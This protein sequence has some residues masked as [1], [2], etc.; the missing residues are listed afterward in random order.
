M[1]VDV[2]PR[3]RPPRHEV[4]QRLDVQI[5]ELRQRMGGLPNPLEAADIWRGIWFE[6]AHHSTAIEGN[7]LVLKQV[8]QLLAEGRAVGNKELSE[9]LEVKGYGDA[10]EWVYGQAI[11]PEYESDEPLTLTEIRKIHHLAMQ[12]VWDIAPH[13]RATAQEGPGEFRRHDIH[14]FPGGMRPPSWVLVAGEMRSWLSATRTLRA[15]TVEFPEQAAEL[16]CRFEQIHP[17]LDG[18]G[19]TGRLVL[20]LLL[21]RLGYPPVIVYKLQRARYLKALRRADAGDFGELGELI[22]RAI[23]D[24]LYKFVVPAIAGPA[25]LVPLAALA[26]SGITAA[27]LRAAAVRGALQAAKGADGQWRSS[28]NWVDEYAATREK[29]KGRPI[30]RRDQVVVR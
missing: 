22:A 9:Y 5:A 20:N 7:T 10:A 25:R 24:N 13:P 30:T 17:F 28:R 8:E 15:G 19:R 14:P 6:E 12:P 23:L 26:T 2:S 27:A 1:L 11:E 16:H 4:Y 3:G 29:R 21:V 18:N